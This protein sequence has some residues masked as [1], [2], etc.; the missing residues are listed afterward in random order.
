MKYRTSISNAD[1]LR[2][3]IIAILFLDLEVD[4]FPYLDHS[5]INQIERVELEIIRLFYMSE[6]DLD[7]YLKELR[8]A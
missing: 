3:R 5:H 2:K 7:R 1:L 8:D 6:K 4:I